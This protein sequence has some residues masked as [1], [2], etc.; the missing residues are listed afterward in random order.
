VTF[1]TVTETPMIYSQL[2]DR[3]FNN[4]K[5]II[6]RE[7]GIKLSDL[8]KALVQARLSRRI[9]LL[10]LTSYDEYYEY[11][12][13]HYEDEKVHFINSITTNKT[14]FFREKKHFDFMMDSALPAIEASG[15]N[16]IRIWSAGCSTGE[17][18]YTIALTVLEYFGTRR[19]PVI[20]I[21][22]TDIDTQVLEK[23][24]AGI[25]T[26]DQTDT[27]PESLMQKYFLKKDSDGSLFYKVKDSVK[28]LVFFRHLN[29]HSEQYPMTKQFDIIFCRNVIIYFDKLMQVKLFSRFRNYLKDTGYLMIGHSENI[30]SIT[31]DFI[32]MG[33]TIYRKNSGYGMDMKKPGK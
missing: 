10:N 12:I 9:R 31:D 1:Q 25:Y 28:Q 4:F 15:A 20:K 3:E 14:E 30:S 26:D 33:N 6:Y 2:Q 21:L 27:V 23:A 19:K 24:Q 29:L 17:E 7:A 11:L 22:A 16:E 5:E 13:E 8:K 18:P 32:L